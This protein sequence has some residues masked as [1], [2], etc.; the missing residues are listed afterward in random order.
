[1]RHPAGGGH[2]ARPP[3]HGEPTVAGDADHP[4]RS[5]TTAGPTSTA[6]SGGTDTGRRARP[7][8]PFDTAVTA[9]TQR[10]T[11][12]GLVVVTGP[13]G[14]GRSTLLR[15]VRAAFP[16]PTHTGGGLSA[17]R[18][19]PALPLSRAVRVRLPTHD[20]HLLAEAVR[21]RLRHGLLVLDDL[22]WADP[23]TI[24][25]LP[26]LARHCRVVVALRTPH[27]LPPAALA[28]LRA[29]DA[30]WLPVP[31]LP[32]PTIAALIR[33]L[34][35]AIDDTTTATLTR[36]AGGNPLAAHALARHAAR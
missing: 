22:H 36:R 21:S 19:V 6:A 20:P 27:H 17:L 3:R 25:A 12:P 14:C 26:A 34:A 1:M 24:A 35:P 8:D 16:G 32:P 18:H 7:A 31:A 9:V 11:R 23:L 15:R 28:P 33:R 30:T 5:A 10:L 13:P 29:D 4:A 2:A